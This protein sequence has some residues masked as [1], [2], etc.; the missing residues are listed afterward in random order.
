M[1]ALDTLK[2]LQTL[3][4]Q[5]IKIPNS[6]AV[7]HLKQLTAERIFHA[8]VVGRELQKESGEPIADLRARLIMLA[9]SICEADGSEPKESV[10]DL[11]G[12]LELLPMATATY[13]LDQMQEVQTTTA[14]EVANEDAISEAIVEQAKKSEAVPYTLS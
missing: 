7:I 12:V 9:A 4:Q 11:L 13:L 1:S 10:R 2:T 6:D 5:A 14:V 3:K 8:G